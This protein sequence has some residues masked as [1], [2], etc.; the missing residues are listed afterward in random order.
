L[1][2]DLFLEMPPGHILTDL[3]RENLPG[4]N[5]VPVEA[6]VLPSLLRLAQE[7]EGDVA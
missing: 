5:S 3:A 1:G 7:A 4:V 2:C 6:S